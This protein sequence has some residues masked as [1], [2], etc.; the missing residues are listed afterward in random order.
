MSGAF[1][2]AWT[3]ESFDVHTDA[4]RDVVI[5]TLHTGTFVHATELEPE[6][7]RALGRA[8]IQQAQGDPQ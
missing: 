7:A 2:D 4:A 1:R 8:L 5:L 6:T 3:E